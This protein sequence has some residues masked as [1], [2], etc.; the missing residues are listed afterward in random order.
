[1]SEP[2]DAGIFPIDAPDDAVQPEG[3]APAQPVAAPAGDS[4][5]L[6][7]VLAAVN[8]L[9]QRLGALE[10]RGNSAAPPAPAAP[11][12]E[13][14]AD[15]NA[16]YANPAAYVDQRAAAAAKS[17]LDAFAGQLTPFFETVAEGLAQRGID[18]ARTQFDSTIGAGAFDKLVADDMSIALAKIPPAQRAN[19]QYVQAIAAGVLGGKMLTPDGQKEVRE[20]MAAAR[21]RPAAPVTLSGNRAAPSPDRISDGE[22]D[23]IDRVRRSGI[24]VDEK[25]FLA[26][27]NRARTEEAWGSDWMHP[28]PP[29]RPN[30]K[31]AA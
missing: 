14:T 26:G 5:S 13:P 20:V 19:A 11:P 31:G 6:A 3:D 28:T 30:G 22:R 23:L 24:A 9:S 16:M 8:G 21:T 7:Q 2:A 17:Q 1:M 25:A 4:E 18:T 10:S 12:V 29:T 27:R 15:F